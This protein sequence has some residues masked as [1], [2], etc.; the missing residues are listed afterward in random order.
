MSERGG[1]GPTQGK[2]RRGKQSRKPVRGP[3]KPRGAGGER[4]RAPLAD[5][6]RGRGGRP[7]SAP[8]AA[9]RPAGRDRDG[10]PPAA[11]HGRR[12]GP[13]RRPDAPDWVIGTHA[14]ES[15]L[16]HAPRRVRALHTWAGQGD[17]L[18]E[19][20]LEAGVL[21]NRGAPP[22]LADGE[23]PGAHLAQGVA[24][25]VTP[26]A[27]ADLDDL[28]ALPPSGGLLLALDSITDTRNLGA[29]LRS[30]GFFGA[31]G[32][33]LPR[34][35]AAAVTAVTERVA[36]GATALTPVAQVTNL[37]RTLQQVDKAGWTIVGS[38]LE[39][40]EG[41]LWD[42]ALDRPVCLVVGAEDRGMRRLVRERCHHVV[43]L[44]AQ[45]PV[46]SLNVASFASLAMAE[47]RRQQGVQ[48]ASAH[49][50][51]PELE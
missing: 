43:T 34:D 31:Q 25:L 20:A 1:R 44:P 51:T 39:G 3:T 14:V 18:R 27:Y 33:I 37:A 9:G 13:G 7:S 36:R 49:H 8:P 28:L 41:A 46:Q 26:F 15:L 32:V 22:H 40:A 29:I 12:R 19:L 23:A 35:R 5:A 2:P 11:R 30:A 16:R 42:A 45:G 4:R 50:P 38:A 17:A 6:E 24:A 48:A 21:A 10:G 47:V